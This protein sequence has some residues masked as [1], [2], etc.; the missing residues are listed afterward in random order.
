[1]AAVNEGF[2]LLFIMGCRFIPQPGLF[3]LGALLV[4]LVLLLLFQPGCPF[5][6]D[7]GGPFRVGLLNLYQLPVGEA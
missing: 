6:Q 2:G 4:E 1:M 5:L 7:T 3:G